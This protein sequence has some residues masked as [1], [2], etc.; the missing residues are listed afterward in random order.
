MASKLRKANKK[1]KDASE[2]Q[3]FS[4]MIP[5]RLSTCERPGGRG[6]R[7]DKERLSR[8][9]AFLKSVGVTTVISLLLE[10]DNLKE[11]KE[12]GLKCHHFPLRVDP[13][14]QTGLVQFDF[15]I[16]QMIA[17]QLPELFG[18][19][20]SALANRREVYCMHLD[21]GRDTIGSII[22]SYFLHTGQAKNAEEAIARVE[23]IK[24]HRIAKRVGVVYEFASATIGN[25]P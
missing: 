18:Y 8:E 11:Y 17:S 24:G 5:G 15:D 20:D 13:P 19:L 3:E 7:H 16:G 22:A 6:R 23:K 4:W 1:V 12:A 10:E 2:P 21:G 14:P 9:I 25:P